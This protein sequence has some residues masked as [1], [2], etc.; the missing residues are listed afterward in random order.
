VH[1]VRLSQLPF[2]LCYDL[3]FLLWALWPH[4]AGGD[5]VCGGTADGAGPDSL[6]ASQPTVAAIYSIL[7]HASSFSTHVVESQA[8]TVS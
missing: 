3:F 4:S 8:R 2:I 5:G 1:A 7:G 6:R